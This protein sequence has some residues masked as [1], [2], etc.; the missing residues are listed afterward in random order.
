MK[1]PVKIPCPEDSAGYGRAAWCFASRAV[2]TRSPRRSPWSIHS[3]TVQS[4]SSEAEIESRI[5]HWQHSSILNRGKK[6]QLDWMIAL[7]AL[8]LP[9]FQPSASRNTKQT[10]PFCRRRGRQGTYLSYRGCSECMAKEPLA[11]AGPDW[12]TA[13]DR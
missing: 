5:R 3:S 11:K 8:L 2:L 6:L 13:A 4:L 10:P 7:V 12:L 1:G 9:V